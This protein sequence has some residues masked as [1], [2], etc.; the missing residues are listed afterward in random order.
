MT[1]T[2]PVPGQP[3]ATNTPLGG[4][5]ATPTCVYST[6]TPTATP[7]PT[8][9]PRTEIQT[10]TP[11][12]SATFTPTPV[13]SLPP[14][15]TPTTTHT[16]TPTTTTTSCVYITPTNTPMGG[17]TPTNTPLGWPTPTPTPTCVY[18]T[19]PVE[20]T[21]TLTPTATA[22]PGATATFTLPGL[23]TATPEV[24]PTTTPPSGSQPSPTPTPTQRSE[25]QA[26]PTP[27]LTTPTGATATPG[28]GAT[29]AATPTTMTS[30]S[31]TPTRTPSSSQPGPT[32]PAETPTQPANE[33]P[34]TPSSQ[35]SPTPGGECIAN[36]TITVF[37]DHN[38]NGRLDTGETPLPGWTIEVQ[39]P[40][41]A[42]VTTDQT[43]RAWLGS[44]TNGASYRLTLVIPAN[45][46]WFTTT[47]SPINWI[48]SCGEALFGVNQIFLPVTG[49]DL[50]TDT[51]MPKGDLSDDPTAAIA[52]PDELPPIGSLTLAGQTLPVK[53]TWAEGHQLLVPDHAAG[54]SRSV[55]DGLRLNW[56]AGQFT[57]RPIHIGDEVR[58]A[59][60]DTAQRYRVVKVETVLA[61]REGMALA[62]VPRD[63][64]LLITCT[65]LHWSHRLLIWAKPE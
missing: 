58:L 1:P 61:G 22:T 9:T 47:P 19:P 33:T 43:G 36:I 23:E 53:A 62:T 60:G 26:S 64:L 13:A 28:S 12:A 14:S 44:L 38:G 11:A 31:P 8:A 27:T 40:G 42:A 18:S 21:P 59:L 35:P 30:T 2:S 29:P 7:S 24:S 10:G 17:P 4:P 57:F 49:A 32:T 54:L 56:H 45:T 16:V 25:A 15:V 34:T 39:G 6:G 63:Q 5:T 65:G 48:G 50:T 55:L 37:Q 20:A 51:G 3:T 41:G 52:S 46:N